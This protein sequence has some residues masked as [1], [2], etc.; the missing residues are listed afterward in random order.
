[1]IEFKVQQVH[2][3]IGYSTN[4]VSSGHKINVLCQENSPRQNTWVSY[5]TFPAILINCHF[6]SKT[7]LFHKRQGFLQ[8]Q[9]SVFLKK[10][11]KGHPTM[12]GILNRGSSFQLKAEST[13]FLGELAKCKKLIVSLIKSGP[14]E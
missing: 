6:L 5:S 14:W 8:K 10:M 1:M 11:Q 4:S 2:Q 7:C 3:K 12:Q 9:A 13:R